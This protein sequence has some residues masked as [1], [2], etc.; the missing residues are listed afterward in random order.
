MKLKEILL[1]ILIIVVLTSCSEKMK[2]ADLIIYN[3]KVYTVDNDFS[4][5][6]SFAVKN[7][8]LIGVG[9][10]D[11]ILNKFKSDKKI[12]AKGKAIYPGF[13]D[14]HCHFYSYG[15]GLISRADLVGT[16]SFEE[17]LKVII[18]F[19]NEHPYEWIEGRGWDQ[20][21][22]EIKKFPDKKALDSLFPNNPVVLIRI[23]GHAVL[24]NSEAMKRAGITKSTKIEGGVIEL[25][26]GELT[27]ILLNNASDFMRE[28]VPKPDKSKKA[29]ALL[30]AQNNC[31]AV[32][33]STI[34]DACLNKD[35]IELIDSLQKIDTFKMRI[36]AMLNSSEE[37]FE[38][39]LY[40]GIYK[41]Q[42]L[43]VRSIKLFSDGAL[44][45]RSACLLQPYSDDPDNY[46]FLAYKPEFLRKMC[47][48]AFENGYQVNTHAIGDSAV[49]MM[50]NI[51]GEFLNGKN[52][53][54]WR[55]EHSQVV[56]PDDFDLFGKYSIIPSV[57]TTHATSD[58]YWAVD[59][60]GKERI[61]GAYA[62]K[63]LLRQNGWIPNG[64]DFPI[65]NINPLY[66]FYSAVFRKD[67][68]AYPENGFQ[69]ENAL[70]R[71]EALKSITIWAAKSCFEE[72]E[73][74]SIEQGKFADFVMLNNDIMKINE[75][76]IPATK[77]LKTFIEGEEVFSME[78]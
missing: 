26:N 17:V 68:Q 50:L 15:L 51:Y 39:Y 44:G 59:R 2:K 54:R 37:N 46:G 65:E 61:K 45:S 57:Q 73:K 70:T 58:M 34:V 55:I 53:L 42:G 47:K 22:W 41:T 72:N 21:D 8:L 16:K 23:G 74:G 3:A 1:L 7:G 31:F 77:V 56:H 19:H 12:D 10:D 32:G 52:D 30:K 33:L 18:D 9:S 62:Y 48:K 71:E 28:I 25:E 27:G 20:N 36:Y 67:L 66:S 78:K 6:E 76:E 63:E 43:N 11:E 75:I 69:K 64:T 60:L 49:R 13:I 14:A 29:H 40:N 24:S 5:K 35:I 38:K 4:I